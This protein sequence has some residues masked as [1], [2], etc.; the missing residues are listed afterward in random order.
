MSPIN[1]VSRIDQIKYKRNKN[2]EEKNKIFDMWEPRRGLEG[3]GYGS[4]IPSIQSDVG[5]ASGI[6]QIEK[7]PQISHLNNATQPKI[8]CES[9][10][11]A[12]DKR[13]DA[14]N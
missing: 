7:S 10:D 2:R 14:K 12:I 6:K 4:V 9:L 13:V 1:K 11:R 5:M 3:F 8:I